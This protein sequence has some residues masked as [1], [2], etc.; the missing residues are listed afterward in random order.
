MAD[1]TGMDWAFTCPEEITDEEIKAGYYALRQKLELEMVGVPT[2]ISVIRAERILSYFV[3]IKQCEKDS[4]FENG[5]EEAQVNNF[6]R[7]L[8]KDW[9]DTI[10]K[11]KP[12]GQEA[13][14]KVERQFKQIFVEV[15][16]AVEM[17]P[18]VRNEL[19]ERFTR[20]V[21]AAGL[22]HG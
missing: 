22:D 11:S 16:A 21:V 3:R 19:A 15:M 5:A 17:P 9:D 20:T 10:I 12:T 1:L 2:S 18:A 14:L 6:L 8:M 4:Q 7:G 13:A